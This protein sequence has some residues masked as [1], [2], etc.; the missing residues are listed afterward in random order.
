MVKNDLCYCD[1]PNCSQGEY[2]V[3]EVGGKLKDSKHSL[4][5]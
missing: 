2:L 5:V 1:I 4:K 3:K